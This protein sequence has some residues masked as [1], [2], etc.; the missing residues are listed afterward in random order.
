MSDPFSTAV[1][2]AEA[3]GK[4]LATIVGLIDQAMKGDDEAIAKLKNVDDVLSPESPTERA[5]E[6]YDRLR[7]AK[8]SR[9]EGGG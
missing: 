2:V 3:G 8:P 9:E 6:R 7:D 1:A 4:L 5:F